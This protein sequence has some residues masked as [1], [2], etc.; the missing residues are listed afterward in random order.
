MPSYSMIDFVDLKK[1][2]MVSFT[3]FEA[4]IG[5]ILYKIRI[6]LP[7][8]VLTKILKLKL[9]LKLMHKLIFWRFC[10]NSKK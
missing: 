2:P 3:L 4:V 6:V 1:S 5:M 9:N 10:L 8:A 7:G